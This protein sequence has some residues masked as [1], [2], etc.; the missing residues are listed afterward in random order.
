MYLIPYL[1][2]EMLCMQTV[3]SVLNAG[4]WGDTDSLRENW[5]TFPKV[6]LYIQL[7]TI[8]TQ[9]SKFVCERLI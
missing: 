2:A 6:P 5:F 9:I 4:Q 7:T 1:Q 8:H 3:Q